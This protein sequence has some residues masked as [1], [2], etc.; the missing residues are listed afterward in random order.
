M[1]LIGYVFMPMERILADAVPINKE[2]L[3]LWLLRN[4]DTD[5]SFEKPVDIYFRESCLPNNV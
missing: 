5:G 1:K 3:P 4:V 2:L